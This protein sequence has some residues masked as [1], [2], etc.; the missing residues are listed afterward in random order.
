MDTDGHMSLQTLLCTWAAGFSLSRALHG[1]SPQSTGLFY[2]Q[3]SE[4]GPTQI[5]LG[6]VRV[7]SGAIALEVRLLFF[8]GSQYWFHFGER[9]GPSHLF[10]KL[11][12]PQFLLV[13]VMLLQWPSSTI[14]LFECALV[15]VLT[16]ARMHAHTPTQTHIPHTPI[17]IST[18]KLASRTPPKCLSDRSPYSWP[19]STL[20]SVWFP[21]DH[22]FRW[23]RM[24]GVW[25]TVEQDHLT[26]HLWVAV[27]LLQVL[28]LL[29]LSFFICEVDKES[30][31]WVS[32]SWRKPT[33]A[34]S[35][36]TICAV[37]QSCL[38]KQKG[39]QG[40]QH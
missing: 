30:T 7:S 3:I 35:L 17:L 4:L 40:N 24:E 28:T 1:L 37:R 14:Y 21:F 11:C 19:V 6:S 15:Y 16:H 38:R 34:M 32:R 36:R 22:R 9:N 10:L 23:G 31:S 12:L 8:W 39:K 29:R 20:S 26:P 33:E 27:W 18:S 13:T 25:G 2:D 5:S